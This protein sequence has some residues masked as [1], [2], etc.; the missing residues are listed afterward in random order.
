MDSKVPQKPKLANHT[1]FTGRKFTGKTKDFKDNRERHFYQRM[2]K[3]YLRGDSRFQFGKSY[4]LNHLGFTELLPD[5]YE[6]QQ[7]YSKPSKTN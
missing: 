3:A 7:S 2:L 6:V 1:E 5:W 4:Q